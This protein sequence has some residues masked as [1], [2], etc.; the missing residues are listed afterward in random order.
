[1]QNLCLIKIIQNQLKQKELIVIHT[2]LHTRK[3]QNKRTDSTNPLPSFWNTISCSLSST[4]S[5]IELF[6][7]TGCLLDVW[8]VVWAPDVAGVGV[9]SGTATSQL[10]RQQSTQGNST[11]KYKLRGSDD[12]TFQSLRRV[13]QV[14]IHRRGSRNQQRYICELLTNGQ[15]ESVI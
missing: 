12:A 5:N 2:M 4:L 10:F 8:T 11:R 7:L 1:M 15:V 14:C 6:L 13:Y 9:V 3:T